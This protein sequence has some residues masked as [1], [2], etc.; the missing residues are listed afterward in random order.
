MRK[1]SEILKSMFRS[2]TV[3]LVTL[4]LLFISCAGLAEAAET[5]SPAAEAVTETPP[6]AVT[7]AVMETL[8]PAAAEAVTASPLSSVTE[9]VTET[10]PPAVTEAPMITVTPAPVED[11][12]DDFVPPSPEPPDPAKQGR[13]T[14]G[15][16]EIPA[17]TVI[18]HVNYPKELRD[19]RFRRDAKLLEIWFPN[20]RDA[21]AAILT[22][23]GQVYMIDCGDEK[24][25]V[26]T[27]VL[28]RQLGID[29]IDIMF[30]SHLH[31]DHTNGLALTDDVAKVGEVKICF[32]TG[33]TAA[34]ELLE[35]VTADRN[36]P[37]TMY[38]SGDWFTMGERGE[39]TLLF[40]RNYD[41]VMDMNNQSAVTVVRY[42]DRSIL[43]TADMEKNGQAQMLK[44]VD[45]A[46][47]KCDILK[48]PHHAKSALYPEFY[49][50][51][52]PKLAVVTSVAG[53]RDLGQSFLVANRIPA[54]Y[55]S[56]KG[57]FLHLATDGEY[58]L[59]E[60]VSSNG[61]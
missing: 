23:D 17:Q 37:V 26:R 42:K 31:H 10:L 38:K 9:A 34:G 59:A 54:A 32:E 60:Y 47:L 14:L 58:W 36:I 56:V 13:P 1:G 61:K 3:I 16:T 4:S 5:L 52:D 24:S 7:E 29:H 51:V 53:R 12:E 27:A 41:P 25:A 44:H 46:L 45:P 8:S 48:Y 28:L 49:Q 40:L 6:P 43:F 2:A 57:Q 30:N 35:Q 19:F 33:S 50:V 22:F 18:D 39:V 11:E 55:T 20:I 21:D 15:P